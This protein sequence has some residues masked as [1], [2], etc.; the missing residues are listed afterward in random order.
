M[1]LPEGRATV[2][3]ISGLT[4]AACCSLWVASNPDRFERGVE[5]SGEVATAYLVVLAVYL[6]GCLAVGYIADSRQLIWIFGAGLLVAVF[7][8]LHDDGLGQPLADLWIGVI[9]D[10][11]VYPTTGAVAVL[12]GT[13]LGRRRRLSDPPV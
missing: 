10:V 5:S 8:P 2:P 12:V 9:G 1:K 3:V 13:L 7:L 4:A 6:R 11:F